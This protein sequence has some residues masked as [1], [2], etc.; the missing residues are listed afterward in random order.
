LDLAEEIYQTTQIKFDEGV[1][2]S[3]ELRQAESD[4]YTAQ[5]NQINA[6]Y[7][8]LDAYTELQKALGKI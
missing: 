8:L 1:G 3:V 6:M 5:S 4:F 2:S 7:D